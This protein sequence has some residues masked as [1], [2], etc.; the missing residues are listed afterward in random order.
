MPKTL[1]FTDTT[2]FDIA[3]P[4]PGSNRR[5]YDSDCPHLGLWMT[6]QGDRVYFAYDPAHPGPD[7]RPIE[8]RIGS[9]EE[10]AVAAAREMA[11][12]L[13]AALSD[14][15]IRPVYSGTGELSRSDA[16]ALRFPGECKSCLD[17]TM[18]NA[19][20]LCGNCRAVAPCA[21][22]PETASVAQCPECRK[23]CC[24]ACLVGKR[25]AS[26][27]EAA[28]RRK[29]RRGPGALPGAAAGRKV[30]AAIEAKKK[31]L[32]ALVGVLVLIQG[33]LFAWQH[34][35]GL[36]SSATPEQRYAQRLGLAMSG[37]SAFKATKGRPPTDAAELTRFLKEQGAE[38]P[39]ITAATTPLPKD[40]VVYV[41]TGD[42]YELYATTSEG[43]RFEPEG[44]AAT[45][46]AP[47]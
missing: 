25:C 43:G 47:D 41:L 28:P 37:V 12:E 14:R 46:I 11:Y 6:A 29:A 15:R 30:A 10:V 40:A 8:L 31:L 18:L 19:E 32:G 36:G 1:C 9:A 4:E 39:P 21:E 35:E 2:P 33:G 20:G 17:M 38:P 7:G 3:L 42:Q 27:A 13:I 22:H 16:E 34:Y 5:V 24:D 44:N 45:L 26:C 23:P